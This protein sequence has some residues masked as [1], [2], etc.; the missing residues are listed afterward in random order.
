M[1]KKTAIK[2]AKTCHICV[3]IIDARNFII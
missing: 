2:A 1:N 3:M